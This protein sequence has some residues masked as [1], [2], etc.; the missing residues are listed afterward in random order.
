MRLR[1]RARKSSHDAWRHV[2]IG[3]AYPMLVQVRIRCNVDDFESC[4]LGNMVLPWVGDAGRAYD[5][6]VRPTLETLRRGFAGHNGATM[7]GTAW[8]W[9]YWPYCTNISLDELD[10]KDRVDKP[11]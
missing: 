10:F 2:L 11:T 8:A 4:A 9:T 1:F 3:L 7:T 5:V 6:F